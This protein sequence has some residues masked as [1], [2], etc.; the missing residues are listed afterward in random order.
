VSQAPR[1]GTSA[2]PRLTVST[3]CP[4]CGAAIDFGEGTNALECD[5]CR[6]HL[7]VTGHGRVLSYF[8]SPK[9]EAKLAISIARFAEAETAGAVRTGA[10]RLVFLPYYRVTATDLRWQRPEP[11]RREEPPDPSDYDPDNFR[12]AALMARLAEQD[13]VDDIECRDR[14]I[15]RNFLAIDFPSPA[16]YSLGVRPNA[17]RL[18]LYRSAAL[19]GLGSLV[20]AEMAADEALEIGRKTGEASDVAC[21]A[22]IGA[23]M[24][25]VYFPFWLVEIRRPQSRSLTIIDGVSQ[26]LVERGLRPELLQRLGRPAMGEPSVVGFRPLVCPNCGWNLPVEPEHVIFYCGSCSRA[27][28]IAGD[29]LVEMSHRFAGP[30]EAV[31]QTTAEHLPFWALRAS[32]GDGGSKPFLAPAF[33]HRRARSLVELATSLSELAPSLASTAAPA[34]ARGGYFDEK[35]AAAIALLAYAGAAP[36]SFERAERCRGESIHVEENELVWIP[37]LSDAY[38][39]RDPFRGMAITRRLL[40]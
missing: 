35:D 22:V 1:L 9:L 5:H 25:I 30:H 38:S 12:I 14:T 33:R 18:E 19:A 16:L 6:S 21:R 37:F 2:A 39:L 13:L 20:G 28:R 31:T 17:L 10:A 3:N 11:E 4:N 27:W 23:V 40:L 32:I 15:E 36:R 24:S 29:D 34:H 8:V 26:A 7:L